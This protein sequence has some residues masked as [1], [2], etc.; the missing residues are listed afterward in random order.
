MTVNVLS[1]ERQ[2]HSPRF[3]RGSM[4]FDSDVPAPF[5]PAGTAFFLAP[6]MSEIQGL[7]SHC[8]SHRFLCFPWNGASLGRG[9]TAQDLAGGSRADPGHLESLGGLG[10]TRAAPHAFITEKEEEDRRTARLLP[11]WCHRLDLPYEGEA[12]KW[13]TCLPSRRLLPGFSK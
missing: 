13:N 4:A 3:L 11:C 1:K 12:F 8:D 10:A 6:S 5:F 2:K 7:L 9:Y